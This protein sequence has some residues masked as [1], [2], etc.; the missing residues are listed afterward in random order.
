MTEAFRAQR[1]GSAGIRI[2]LVLPGLAAGGTERVVNAIANH[3]AE[4][5]WMV[6]I[7]TLEPPGKPSY[8]AYHPRVTMRRLGLPTSGEPKLRAIFLTIKRILALR[9]CLREVWPELIVTFLTRTNVLTML[10]TG[11]MGIPVVVS[12][13]NNAELQYCG[14][15]WSWLRRRLYPHAFGL[16]AMTRGALEFFPAKMRPR[17][18]VIPNPVYLPD[19]WQPSR[20]GHVLAAVG[21]LVP[22]KGF[23]LLLQAFGE[24]AQLFPEW[25]LVI[26]GEGVE[27]KNLE[28]QRDHLGLQNRV[29]LPGVSELPGTWV[30]TADA[31]VLSSRFE[32]WGIVLLEAMA[33]ELPV[34]SFDCKWGPREMIHDGVDGLLVPQEDV[35]ALA[36]ALAKV[37]RDAG[38]RQ[39]LGAA[40]A[41]SAQR[42]AP[43]RIMAS[44]DEMVLAALAER[45]SSN[46]VDK[47]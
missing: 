34:V 2:A 1:V 17:S 14:P 15:V 35:A 21:R 29:R 18:W 25:T 28:K 22:Q 33:A 16:V 4:R 5:G 46:R 13:R 23:D 41:K 40:A 26:W 6:T 19:G 12:E 7:L 20:G 24:I 31:F 36:R 47:E 43:D 39:R 44:W 45:P 9:R 38:L 8:F 37:M 11:G 3:W 32:G 10:A 27:R 30:E 42:F